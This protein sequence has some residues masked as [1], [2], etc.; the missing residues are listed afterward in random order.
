M[1]DIRN[2]EAIDVHAHYGPF[3]RGISA[4]VDSLRSCDAQ[5]VVARARLAHVALTVVSPATALVPRFE[6]DA[7]AGNDE[8]ERT[9]AEVEGLRRWVVVN[10]LQP[11]TYEQAA[12]ALS[13]SRCV[14]IKIHPEEHGYAICAHGGALLE[15]AAEHRAVVLTHSGEPNSMPA[16][17]VRFADAFAQVTVIL[18]HLGHGSDGDPTHQ[19]R[20]IQA[21]RRGNIN[22][23]TS[24][25]Q[26]LTPGLIEWAVEQVGPERLLFGTDSPVYW[27]PMQRA[28]IDSAEI[29]DESKRL[30]LRDNALRLLGLDLEE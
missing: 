11:R 9:V 21:A 3:H 27:A 6:A 13:Q 17:Y 16:D 12:E 30:I 18:A 19:V 2:V 14:G 15:F 29:E 23:D 5:G 26:N 8:A 20:A 24:S 10:P 28:R 22:A 7:V 1:T 4:L 25:A